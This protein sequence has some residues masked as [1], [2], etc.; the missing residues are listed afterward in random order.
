[1]NQIMPII[2]ED[3]KDPMYKQLFN[4]VKLQILEG[5]INKDEKLPSLRSLSKSLNISLT[6]VGLAYDQLLV[7]GY[8]YSKRGS[9]YFVN[10]ISSGM[11][12]PI[13]TKR[14][15]EQFAD[16]VESEYYFDPATFDFAKW[17]KCI[18]LVLSDESGK[19]FIEGDSQGEL[20]LRIEISKY[21][22]Q[23]RG[24]IASP[25]QIVVGAGTQQIHLVSVGKNGIE[26]E[27][28]QKI[29]SGVYVSPS[30]QFPTGAVIPIGK[31]YELL[32]WAAKNSSI[33]IEDDYD[34]ELRYF[35]KPI[36]AL[37]G[38]D[39][40]GLVVYLGSFSSTLY[41]SVKISYMILPQDMARIFEKHKSQYTQTCSKVE[42]LAL[43]LYMQ[44]GQYQIGIKKLRA[45]C[46]QKLQIV[47]SVFSRKASD[48]IKLANTSSGVN[49]ILHVSSNHGPEKLCAIGKNIGIQLSGVSHFT[50]NHNDINDYSSVILYFNQ[51][52]I[53]R[54][55]A[56]LEELINLWRSDKV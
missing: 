6:T 8:I 48:F 19:L 37:Q 2:Q 46:S 28:L 38:L 44:R 56:A 47:I 29:K 3:I 40:N 9:G 10:E 15:S 12:T 55:A 36:P 51:I 45:L 30:N 50:E 42:Q 17:K 35:G 23:S 33:I 27:K 21:L 1:M 53:N 24:V 32:A 25:S 13:Y 11:G 5:S 31:R 41:P 34:S 20:S 18:N 7:E 39:N 4:H 49:V 14:Y 43:S 16:S 52:P 22:Y 54:L 26:I